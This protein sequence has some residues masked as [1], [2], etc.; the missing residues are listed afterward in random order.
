MMLC[1]KMS[2][3]S[4]FVSRAFHS[5]VSVCHEY[6]VIWYVKTYI[7]TANVY[8]LLYLGR[9]AQINVL[10]LSGIGIDNCYQYACHMNRKKNIPPFEYDSVG[11]LYL[12]K[13]WPLPMMKN[14]TIF[15]IIEISLVIS[16][17]TGMQ[18]TF[19]MNVTFRLLLGRC[20][21]IFIFLTP[22]LRV[23]EEPVCLHEESLRHICVRRRG[24]TVGHAPMKCPGLRNSSH[25]AT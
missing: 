6:L 4:L 17:S 14:M 9:R 5:V 1:A 7:K 2:V 12:P 23:Y 3:Q 16:G 15:Q 11:W 18:G 22:P 19:G 24:R 8:Q 13:Y 21:I 10:K 25:F 20:R